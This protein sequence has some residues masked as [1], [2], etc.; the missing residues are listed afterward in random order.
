MCKPER[1]RV[2]WKE[3]GTQNQHDHCDIPVNKSLIYKQKF[4]EA[5]HI[6]WR[7][8]KSS[9]AWTQLKIHFIRS[10]FQ[11]RFCKYFLANDTVQSHFIKWTFSDRKR[12]FF[13]LQTNEKK[14]KTKMWILCGIVIQDYC[15]LM[16]YPNFKF[17][18]NFLF[19]WKP[20]QCLDILRFQ[21]DSFWCNGRIWKNIRQFCL[22]WH[23]DLIRMYFPC[24]EINTPVMY[25][26]Q[27]WNI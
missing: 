3:Y 12:E 18:F 4:R 19:Q 22:I 9:K 1:S 11:R 10:E 24:S 15:T 26:Y 6:F 7:Q 16:Y 27:G 20:V 2:L 5:W 25:F 17:S 8:K 23:S 14:K 21:N 13:S